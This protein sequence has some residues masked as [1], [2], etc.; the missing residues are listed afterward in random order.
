[1]ERIELGQTVKCTQTGFVG[2]VTARTDYLHGVS[3]ICVQPKCKDD[4]K[5]PNPAWIDEPLLE[6]SPD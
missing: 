6:V 2:L 3:R 1:M 5:M 4:G